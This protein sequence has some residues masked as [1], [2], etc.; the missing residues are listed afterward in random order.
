M[1]NKIIIFLILASLM[2]MNVNAEWIPGRYELAPVKDTYVSIAG[3]LA[4]PTAN[5]GGA[6]TLYAGSGFDGISVTAIMF[7]LSTIGKPLSKLTFKADVT[8]YD[9]STRYLLVGVVPNVDWNEYTVTGVDNPFNATDFGTS[10]PNDDIVYTSTIVTG[11]TEEV[12]FELNDFLNQTGTLTILLAQNWGADGWVTLDAKENKYLSGFSNPPHLEYSVKEITSTSQSASTGAGGSGSDSGSDSDSG[13]GTILFLAAVGGGI[14]FY[15]KRKS[16]KQQ[17]I[18][19]PP[20]NNN[21][22]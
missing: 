19:N 1:R 14:Y 5:Y 17:P 7:D 8:V 20:I 22:R 2:T 11:S 3:A 9:S 16:K 12:S 13:A 15:R 6:E 4:N 10:S 18:Y 21:I